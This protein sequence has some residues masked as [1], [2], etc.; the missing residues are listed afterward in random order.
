MGNKNP[1]TASDSL[2]L[3]RIAKCI[4]L[5]MLKRVVPM[6]LARELTLT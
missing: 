1:Q 6:E 2:S 5:L 3:H 4:T